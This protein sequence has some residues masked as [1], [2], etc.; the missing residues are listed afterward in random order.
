VTGDEAAERAMEGV[1]ELRKS[2]AKEGVKAF[3]VPCEAMT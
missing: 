3:V 1:R 2:F